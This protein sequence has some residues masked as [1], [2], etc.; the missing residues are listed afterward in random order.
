MNLHLRNTSLTSP[1]ALKRLQAETAAK[2]KAEIAKAETL[3]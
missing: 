1:D 3:K 2:Q